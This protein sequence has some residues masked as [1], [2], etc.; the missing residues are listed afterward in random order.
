M[1]QLR[2]IEKTPRVQPPPPASRFVLR[3]KRKTWTP[4]GSGRSTPELFLETPRFTRFQLLKFFPSLTPSVFCPHV[5]TAVLKGLTPLQLATLFG[6]NNY[7]KLMWG[8]ILVL[9]RKLCTLPPPKKKNRFFEKN[10]SSARRRTEI[11]SITY[12][13]K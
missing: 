7:L 5:G 8:G 4:T 6:R 13:Y 1:H 9:L 11:N 12:V 10:E 2:E 3:S